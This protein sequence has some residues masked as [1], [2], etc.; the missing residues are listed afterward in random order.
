MSESMCC[1][2]SRAQAAALGLALIRVH[3]T[4]R[5]LAVQQRTLRSVGY[6]GAAL[7][8]VV[9]DKRPAQGSGGG[10]LFGLA[11]L[12]GIC[13]CPSRSLRAAKFALAALTF[14]SKEM[15]TVTCSGTASSCFRVGG[16]SSRPPGSIRGPVRFRTKRTPGFDAVLHL[17]GPLGI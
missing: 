9:G 15:Q 11:G 5:F 8:V 7:L 16:P 2:N 4:N 1:A 10:P 6:T 13:P 17:A 3:E 12:L 14:S